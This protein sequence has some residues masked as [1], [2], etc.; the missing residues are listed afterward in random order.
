MTLSVRRKYSYQGWWGVLAVTFIS[1]QG[2][3]RREPNTCG[4]KI[5]PGS[6]VSCPL[7]AGCQL[8]FFLDSWQL[9]ADN[10][11]PSCWRVAEAQGDC[12][13]SG[14]EWRLGAGSRVGRRGGG[15]WDESGGTSGGQG[16]GIIGVFRC[17][18]HL[19][20]CKITSETNHFSSLTNY[21][22]SWPLTTD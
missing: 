12:R 2:Q 5:R 11:L 3:D 16:E 19:L 13:S 21:T 20:Q 4:C 9:T 15:R 10:D 17:V 22:D 7:G 18:G 14:E 8:S 6:G 1:F